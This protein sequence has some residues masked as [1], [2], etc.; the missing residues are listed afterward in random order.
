ML[1]TGQLADVPKSILL[2]RC[3]GSRENS[4]TISLGLEERGSE[5][6]EE[7]WHLT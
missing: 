2:G 3:R 1:P 7:E 4:T 5:L 6:E